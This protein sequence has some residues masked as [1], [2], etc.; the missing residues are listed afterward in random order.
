MISPV[1]LRFDTVALVCSLGG[2][3]MKMMMEEE[4][5][6]PLQKLP[7]WNLILPGNFPG[8]CKQGGHTGEHLYF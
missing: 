5:F 8:L 7:K 1:L 6:R 3:W 2:H 4:A